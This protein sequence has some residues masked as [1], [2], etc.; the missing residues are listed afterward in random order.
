MVPTYGRSSWGAATPNRVCGVMSRCDA[1]VL[2]HTVGLHPLTVNDAHVEMR[3]LQR[4]ALA[5]TKP[6][7]ELE[8][9]DIPYNLVCGPDSIFVGRGPTINDGATDDD[10]QTHTVSVS[11]MG[12]FEWTTV[13][14]EY[15]R[16]I[17]DAVNLCRL[18]W[19]PLEVKPHKSYMNTACPGAHLLAMIPDLNGDD[20]MTADEFFKRELILSDGE[21]PQ[22]YPTNVEG[23]F[24]YVHRELQIIRQ[25][26]AALKGT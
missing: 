17:I 2:H 11:V 26:V 23:W 5:K 14:P 12:N 13:S 7:G 19:G 16:S 1:I 9:C 22:P 15:R 25:E 8:Y 21:P 20:E 18:V 6:N 3:R 10:I 4:E 24:V